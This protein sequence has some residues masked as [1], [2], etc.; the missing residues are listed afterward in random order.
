LFNAFNGLLIGK[1]YADQGKMDSAFFAYRL[2][3]QNTNQYSQH[4]AAQ[5]NAGIA[6]LYQQA[7]KRDSALYFAL[8]AFNYF[9]SSNRN[10]SSMVW[11]E[12]P[13]YSLADLAPLVAELY[14]DRREMDSA[15][16]YL[17]MSVTMKDSLYNID[18]VRQFQ[19]L[20]F[21]DASRRQQLEQQKREAEQ[22]YQTRIKIYGLLS[23]ITGFLVLSLVFYRNNKA[24]QRANALLLSQKEEI[25]K[26]LGDLK[27]TQQQLIQSEKMASLGELTAGIAH[28]IQ[29]PLNFVNNFAEVNSELIGEMKQ[30]IDQGNLE[31]V[32]SIAASIDENEQ[33][34]LFHGR[35]ADGIVKGMLQHSRSSTGQKEPTDVN[36]LADEYL[37]LAY[38]GL[39]ARDKGFNAVMKT[40]YDPAL[41]KANLIPQD[42]GRVLL[43]LFT[44]AFYSVKQKKKQFPDGYEPTIWVSTRKLENKIEVRVRDNGLG[45]PDT[46]RNKIFQPFFTT[47]PTGEGTG[48]GLSLSFDIITKVHGGE[49][50]LTT[51]AGD[52][53]EFLILLP[54]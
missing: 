16:K 33:K 46:V 45:V 2:T 14:K 15:W 51:K 48:L 37:R 24:K 39:R 40:D 54:V 25:E 36:Q 28:E 8:A 43:N 1:I 10:M 7:G 47:K 52:Y 19:T 42:I 38:H 22:Q 34:I 18:K 41:P 12:N 49:L 11:G 53:A 6:R 50:K 35:R 32:K 13:N 3:L 20:T 31:E 26:T 9:R 44:N 17:Q 4:L 5:A 29:N 30:E 21:N 23:V 27:S